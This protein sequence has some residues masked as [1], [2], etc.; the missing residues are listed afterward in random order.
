MNFF[1]NFVFGKGDD[2]IPICKDG[3][4][5][6]TFTMDSPYLKVSIYSLYNLESLD[7]N[8]IA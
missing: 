7:Y 3:C 5:Q 8:L 2:P 6:E 1:S 4:S